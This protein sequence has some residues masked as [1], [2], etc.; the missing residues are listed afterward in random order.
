M[1]FLDYYNYYEGEKLEFDFINK[2]SKT[3]YFE[4]VERHLAISSSILA[5]YRISMNWKLMVCVFDLFMF[6]AKL[7]L[8][9][10]S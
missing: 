1:I 10:I 2:F 6:Y 7:F 9:K 5:I 8:S 3:I 4:F